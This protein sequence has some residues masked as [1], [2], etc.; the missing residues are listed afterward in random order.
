MISRWFVACVFTVVACGQDPVPDYIIPSTTKIADDATKNALVA[1]NDDGSLV[2]STSTGVLD[3]LAIGDILNSNVVPSIAPYGYLRKVTAID[4]SG[5]GVT[6]QTVEGTLGEAIERGSFDVSHQI[7]AAD[8]IISPR[9]GAPTTMVP[10]VTFDNGIVLGFNAFEASITRPGDATI[11]ATL[12]ID[13]HMR[14]NP[15]FSMRGEIRNFH[16]DS[17][18]VSLDFEG[19]SDLA[20]AVQVAAGFDENTQFYHLTLGEITF[21]IG[22]VIVVIAPTLHFN[23]GVAGSAAVT[24]SFHEVGAYDGLCGARYN[25]GNGWT[26]LNRG[27]SSGTIDNL[28]TGGVSAELDAYVGV[29][30]DALLYNAV[31]TGPVFDIKVGPS[32]DF[33]T[34]RDPF[35]QAG[36]RLVADLAMH[37]YG[38]GHEFAEVTLTQYNVL[39]PIWSSPNTAPILAITSPGPSLSVAPDFPIHFQAAV[40]DL[41]DGTG[42][43]VTWTSNLDGV[44]GTGSDFTTTLHPTAP[45]PRTITVTATDSAGL[46]QTLSF[47]LTLLNPGP[48][49]VIQEPR[50]NQALWT[51]DSIVRGSATSDFFPG[52]D[53]CGAG[54]TYQWTSSLADVIG[55]VQCN[56]GSA[57]ATITYVS[58]GPRILTLHVTDPFG[59]PQT[60]TRLATVGAPPA[61][62]YFGSSNFSSPAAGSSVS[63][64]STV[65]INGSADPR[66]V[67]TDPYPFATAAPL[68]FTFSATSYAADDVTP[69]ATID[70][71]SKVDIDKL[72][73]GTGVT[74]PI[75]WI[76][77]S[78]PGFIDPTL[79]ATGAG[80]SVVLSFTAIDASGH[81]GSGTLAIKVTP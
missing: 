36:I 47:Q 20:M 42:V 31:S 40:Y 28:P 72:T 63:A 45:G 55:P 1:M 78:T 64:T 76:P 74:P 70:I 13:G 26:S 66:K 71:G 69:L 73:A 2:F 25:D 68:T 81:F 37:L 16:V 9:I 19:D 11:G 80:Q 48:M 50:I 49:P 59:T 67:I 38:F 77:G 6:L 79:A 75:A 12:D 22:P 46:A 32:L 10:T 29:T 4:R 8:L 56:L 17:F 7:T 18:E 62:T 44:I 21:P 5:G 34:P 65:L 39:F 57:R 52:V 58:A 14:F 30:G 33:A 51:Y 61:A 24:L 23:V 60:A 3:S 15:T 41:E 43:S 53:L 35:L 54:F 27:N